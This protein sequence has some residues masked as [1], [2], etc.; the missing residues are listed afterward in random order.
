MFH[1]AARCESALRA[2]IFR[3]PSIQI[4][5]VLSRHVLHGLAHVLI[6]HYWVIVCHSMPP[7]QRRKRMFP[8]APIRCRRSVL[9]PAGA[10]VSQAL[11]SADAG[12]RRHLNAWRGI[13]VAVI[14][15]YSWLAIT[16]S[17]S[18]LVRMQYQYDLGGFTRAELDAYVRDVGRRFV[19]QEM[20]RKQA[21]GKLDP[22]ATPEDNWYADLW[23]Y[24]AENN[25]PRGKLPTLGGAPLDLYK[26]FVLIIQRGGLQKT[27]DA[28][29]F[30]NVAKELALPPTCTAAAFA[31]RQAY[32]RL[33]Y[34]YEQKFLF[35]R[36][37]HEAPPIRQ[38]VK[39]SMSFVPRPGGSDGATP[40]DSVSRIAFRGFEGEQ[41]TSRSLVRFGGDGLVSG[42][43]GNATS[44][45]AA[46]APLTAPPTGQQHTVRVS[47]QVLRDAL[48]GAGGLLLPFSGVS[49]PYRERIKQEVAAT[50]SPKRR[51]SALRG[52]GRSVGSQRGHWKERAPPWLP[53]FAENLNS[54][55]EKLVLSL[56]SGVREEVRWALTT[57]NALCSGAPAGTSVSIGGRSTSGRL[58]LRCAL[59]P[60]LLDALNDLLDAYLEDLE[61]RRQWSLS[62]PQELRECR[63]A[64]LADLSASALETLEPGAGNNERALDTPESSLQGYRAGL[65]NCRDTIAKER[66]Q[67]SLLVTNALR[68][69]SFTTGNE[70]AL[71]THP[72]LRSTTLRLLRHPDTQPACVDDLLDMWLNIASSV[73]LVS[74]TDWAN[75]AGSGVADMNTLRT[76]AEHAAS[77]IVNGVDETSRPAAQV[78]APAPSSGWRESNTVRRGLAVTGDAHSAHSS[79]VDAL[80]TIIDWLDATHPNASVQRMCKAAEI[81]AQFATRLENETIMITRFPVLLPRLVDMVAPGTGTHLASVQL[82]MAA[83]DA[84][85]SL[86]AFEWQAR[87]R[88]A[89]TPRLVPTLVRVVAAAVAQQEPELLHRAGVPSP[90]ET[91]P[92]VTAT[93]GAS[94]SARAALVLLNLAENPH[95]RR[96]LLPYELVLVYGAMTDKVAGTALA[97][98]LHELVAD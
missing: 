33:A 77:V 83:L 97:S 76:N 30:K 23:A 66:A 28:R 48:M 67:Y 25:L 43:H 63:G 18:T 88:I 82:S 71:A 42:S 3:V 75:A 6:V 51:R 17:V 54:E 84:L 13:V 41:A 74:R 14:N 87:E 8:V 15:D 85:A 79:R 62:M 40:E 53:Y 29:D 36:E 24:L 91:S 50:E 81:V 72:A 57:L 70:I 7:R 21:S 90:S 44:G 10:L 2:R 46:G 19:S 9:V 32:E 59:Y 4:H 93:I 22:A 35:N 73:T 80:D 94:L 26:L 95:N 69:M 78:D 47:K 60:G 34:V 92:R 49:V 31:L 12:C 64:H 27:I 96:L 16:R 52:N 38:A 20:Q 11:V 39:S 65:M 55:R 89:R 56:Q 1:A 45:S 98:V 5:I 86:S 61:R 68:N 37:P 58:E